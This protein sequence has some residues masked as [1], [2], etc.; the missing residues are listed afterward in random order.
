MGFTVVSGS[1]TITPTISTA[2]AAA[3]TTWTDHAGVLQVYATDFRYVKVTLDFTSSGG[4]DLLLIDSLI[5]RLD[6]KIKRDSGI[7]TANSGDSGGTTVNFAEVFIDIR[8]ITG[9]PQGTT[10]AVPVIDFTDAPNPTSFKILVFDLAG[11]RITRDVRWDASG[12]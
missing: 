5:V 10:P 3:P 7:V 4:N 2:T 9:T 8:S 12:V 6:V 11:G 1:V